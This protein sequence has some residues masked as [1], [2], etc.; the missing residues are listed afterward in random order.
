MR[1]D[2]LLMGMTYLQYQ[3][4]LF[5]TVIVT[6]TLNPL[7]MSPTVFPNAIAIHRDQQS[8]YLNHSI[9]FQILQLPGQN[10]TICG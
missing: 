10:R 2:Q 7:E 1:R 4:I 9:D 8:L 6:I 5:I 3:N